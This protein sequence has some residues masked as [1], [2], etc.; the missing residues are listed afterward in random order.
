MRRA[1]VIISILLAVVFC[2]YV[3]INDNNTVIIYDKGTGEQQ[4]KC[5]TSAGAEIIDIPYQEIEFVHGSTPG[6]DAVSG[7]SIRKEENVSTIYRNRKKPELLQIY[8]PYDKASFPLNIAPP[9]FKWDDLN[10]NLWLVE[11]I[12]ENG[13]GVQVVTRKQS[14]R[15]SGRIWSRIKKEAAGQYVRLQVSG[16]KADNNAEENKIHRSHP[17][18]FRISE[19][20]AD[21]VVVYRFVTPS[22]TAAKTPDIFIRYLSDFKVKTFLPCKGRFCA[23]CHTF[24]GKAD[25]EKACVQWRNMVEGG[26]GFLVYDIK[27]KTG[28]R[29][30][31]P[32]GGST[33]V[34]WSPDGKKLALT[35]RQKLKTSS[36]VT[37]ETQYAFSPTADIAVYDTEKNS[38]SLLPGASDPEYL[39]NYPR[40][41]LDG[42]T[43]AFCRDRTESA[44][45][46][47][48]RQKYSIFLIPYNDGNGGEPVPLKGASFN[49]MSNYYPRFSP[50]GKWLSFCRSKYGSLIKPSSD[51]YI[52]SREEG[53]V[54]RLECNT[55][56]AADSWHSWS[57]NSRWLIFTSKRDDGIFARL[58]L[59]EINKKGL[60]SPPVMLPEK[61]FVPKSYNVPEFQKQ[62]PDVDPG[63]LYKVMNKGLIR[64]AEEIANN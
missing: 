37:L 23:S 9:L 48:Y 40:W 53:T 47:R 8:R 38:I 60:S 16:Y 20:P 17:V 41:S 39:E 64:N 31:I 19:F 51:I 58:Y 42:E 45:E 21:E 30:K 62:A 35:V 44:K 63:K 61:E 24:T 59:T 57:S 36:P 46:G 11:F 14:W 22:F 27:E 54:R 26:A 13:T 4:L 12:L 10:N 56:Y 32:L 55:E 5:F 34:S 33:F 25:S 28:E 1:V 2:W 29:I 43:I 50:D 18:S 3:S 6:L 52:Y 49:G 7:A 15:P